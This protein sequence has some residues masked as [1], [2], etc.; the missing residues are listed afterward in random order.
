MRRIEL[1]T[2]LGASAER[3]WD[4]LLDLDGWPRW[5]GLVT[6]AQGVLEPGARWTMTLRPEVVGGRAR[7]M[8]PRF[9]SVDP[10]RQVVFET[11]LLGAWFV[12]LVH[13]FDVVPDGDRAVLRQSFRATGLGVPLLWPVLRDGMTQFDELGEDLAAWLARHDG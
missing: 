3:A 4:V 1:N 13:V 12:R 9:V 5:G 10:P 6:S 7:A 11:L 2:P 8:R